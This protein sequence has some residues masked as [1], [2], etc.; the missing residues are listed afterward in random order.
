MNFKTANC[1]RSKGSRNFVRAND[2][3]NGGSGSR[4]SC[5]I[6]LFPVISFHL[7]QSAVVVVIRSW[8]TRTFFCAIFPQFL[9]FGGPLLLSVQALLWPKLV[10][11]KQ[12]F[13]LPEPRWVGILN[14]QAWMKGESLKK[15]LEIQKYLDTGGLVHTFCITLM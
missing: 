15:K 11:A 3:P 13:S 2:L 9:N 6:F 4:M 7:S 12:L 10:M 14:G 8:N 5:T 1:T